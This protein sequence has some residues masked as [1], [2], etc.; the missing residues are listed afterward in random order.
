MVEKREER[1]QIN[2]I[3][4]QVRKVYLESILV[5]PHRGWVG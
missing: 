5:T 3:E 4:G 1:G 2:K